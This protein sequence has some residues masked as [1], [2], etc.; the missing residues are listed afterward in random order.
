[1]IKSNTNSKS[2]LNP[3]FKAAKK[4]VYKMSCI[5]VTLLC[6]ID[7]GNQDTRRKPQTGHQ[8]QICELLPLL[9]ILCSS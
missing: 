8:L 2:V 1:M 6:V 4:V 9:C 3:E 5:G 7:G